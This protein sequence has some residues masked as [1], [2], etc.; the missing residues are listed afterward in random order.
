VRT[1]LFFVV[2]AILAWGAYRYFYLH[3]APLPNFHW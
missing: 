3:Q 1:I 2:A